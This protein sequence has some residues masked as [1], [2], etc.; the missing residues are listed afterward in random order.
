MLTCGSY[1]YE[2]DMWAMGCILG[3][4]IKSVENSHALTPKCF[5]SLSKPQ[6]L[7]MFPGFKN[8]DYFFSTHMNYSIRREC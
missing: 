6:R 4:M 8:R 1:S 7:A 3:E 2:V 5:P